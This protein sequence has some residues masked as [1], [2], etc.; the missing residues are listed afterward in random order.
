[1]ALEECR[2][3]LLNRTDLHNVL[4]RNPC[5]VVEVLRLIAIRI[6]YVTAQ[7]NEQI[8]LPLHQKLARI[9]LRLASTEEN[10]TRCLRLS[11][12]ELTDLVGSSREAVSKALSAW[13]KQGLLL[14]ARGSIELIN[15]TELRRV[16]G[17]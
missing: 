16:A 12:S 5:L 3:L 17:L 6:C 14:T 2:L 7:L 10:G 1:M 4:A 15:E 11:H 9:L 13:N 8:L